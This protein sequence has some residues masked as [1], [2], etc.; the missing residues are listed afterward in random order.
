MFYN[1]RVNTSS[2]W[3]EMCIGLLHRNL[4]TT[5]LPLFEFCRKQMLFIL[6]G[7][8][9]FIHTNLKTSKISICL[10]AKGPRHLGPEFLF[11][12]FTI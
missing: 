3:I 5:Y 2:M 11:E 4:K 6:G 8:S 12:D 9:L 10:L 7:K 1:T